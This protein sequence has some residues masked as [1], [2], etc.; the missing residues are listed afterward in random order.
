MPAPAGARRCGAPAP[1]PAAGTSAS[2]CP[3]R[4]RSRPAARSR[5]APARLGQPPLDPRAQLA[6]P[7][8]PRPRSGARAGSTTS[9][10]AWACTL[11]RTLPRALR[12][13]HHVGD[14]LARGMPRFRAERTHRRGRLELIAAHTLCGAWATTDS[15]TG[16]AEPGDA[17]RADPRRGAAA[18]ARGRARRRCAPPTPR[19]S[20]TSPA[21]SRPGSR[22]SR[23]WGGGDRLRLRPHAARAP[24]LRARARARATASDAPATRSSPAAGRA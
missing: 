20:T 9:T 24:H 5:P 23:T 18:V 11:T 16:A 10:S 12:A 6:R 8:P 7:R 19:A 1:V 22:R 4:G 13:P 15:R 14:L 3:G 17:A 21:S 2:G